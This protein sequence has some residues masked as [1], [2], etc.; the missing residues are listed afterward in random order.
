MTNLIRNT[1]RSLTQQEY[2]KGFQTQPSELDTIDGR[3]TYNNIRPAIEAAE[4][5]L[6]AI[7]SDDDSEYGMLY[8]LKNT[9][10][11]PDGP[12]AEIELTPHPGQAPVWNDDVTQRQYCNAHVIWKQW[13]YTFEREN[14]V[15]LAIKESMLATLPKALV[16]KLKNRR[17]KYNNVTAKEMYDAYREYAP[18]SPEDRDALKLMLNKNG[19]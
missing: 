3:A 6:I 8:I 4:G 2:E 9:S 17:T 11:M 16:L 10:V 14:N 13:K 12:E 5:N 19:T 15:S 1:N 18:A 7:K